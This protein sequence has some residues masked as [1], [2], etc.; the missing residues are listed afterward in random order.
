M[1]HAGIFRPQETGKIGSNPG[2]CRMHDLILYDGIARRLD[3]WRVE[4]KKQTRND[5]LEAFAE[6]RPSWNKIITMSYMMAQTYVAAGNFKAND[7]PQVRDMD[8]ENSLL[9]NQY[10]L[11]YEDEEIT[12]AMNHGDIGHVED[13]LGQWIP[14]FKSTGKNKYS[15]LMS[16]FLVDLHFLYPE[17]LW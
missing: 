7:C 4:V 2:F 14:I 16:R 12:W 8:L 1:E 6:S 17:R 5:S 3:C 13:A 11:L 9:R 10:Y 15:T